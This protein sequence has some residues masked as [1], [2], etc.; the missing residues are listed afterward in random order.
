LSRVL[1]EIVKKPIHNKKVIRWANF[2]STSKEL[3]T[4]APKSQK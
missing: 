2:P 4:T 3:K 1:E